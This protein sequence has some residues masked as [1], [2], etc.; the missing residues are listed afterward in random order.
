MSSVIA[1]QSSGAL[2]PNP[3]APGPAMPMP[4]PALPNPALPNPAQQNPTVQKPLT[5]GMSGMPVGLPGL[6]GAK[7]PANIYQQVI[8]FTVFF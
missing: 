2:A 4:K 8:S 3:V 7:N 1:P 5:P 6:A